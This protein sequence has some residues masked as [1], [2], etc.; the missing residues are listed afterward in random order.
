MLYEKVCAQ[1]GDISVRLHSKRGKQKPQ[2]ENRVAEI[3]PD[4]TITH[5]ILCT[6]RE[7]D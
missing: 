2:N 4:T 7:L 1:A 5:D 6:H 3:L